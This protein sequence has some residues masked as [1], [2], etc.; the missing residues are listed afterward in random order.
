[1]ACPTATSIRGQGELSNDE[2]YLDEREDEKLGIGGGNQDL[3]EFEMDNQE[4][5]EQ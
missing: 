3:E 5:K 1:V 4:A 2:A